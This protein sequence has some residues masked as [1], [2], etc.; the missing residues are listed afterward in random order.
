[1][2]KYIIHT[3]V[4]KRDRSGNCYNYS[5]ITS[6]KTKKS[7]VVND[8]YGSN[9]NST[10]S[11]VRELMGLEWPEIYYA[12]NNDMSHR[13]LSKKTAGMPCLYDLKAI[14]LKRLNR[15]G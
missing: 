3:F 13:E 1:M 8:G 7:L 11:I 14:D 5:I 4:S 10:V 6:T 15:K 12:E 9:G 2:I